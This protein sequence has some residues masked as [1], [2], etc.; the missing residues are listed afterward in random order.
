[1]LAGERVL[2]PAGGRLHRELV[3]VRAG[4]ERGFSP[5][6]SET[7]HAHAVVLLEIE[8]GPAQLVER[9]RVQG[10]EHLRPVDRQVGDSAVALEKKRVEGHGS[11]LQQERIHQPAEHGNRHDEAGEHHAAVADLLL[12]VVFGDHAAKTSET[13]NANRISSRR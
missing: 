7:D 10:V 13:K 1:M 8:D 3:D 2:A 12:D 4:D 9:L 6:P 5:A 11:T